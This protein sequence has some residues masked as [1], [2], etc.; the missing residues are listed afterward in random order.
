MR[1]FTE[2]QRCGWLYWNTFLDGNANMRECEFKPKHST[3]MVEQK[4]VQLYKLNELLNFHVFPSTG[5]VE[6]L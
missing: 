6:G 2:L 1:S 5:I 3:D 4:G